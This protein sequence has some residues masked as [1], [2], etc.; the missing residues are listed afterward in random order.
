[1]AHPF[2]DSAKKTSR[3]KFKAISGKSGLSEGDVDGAQL[4]PAPKRLVEAGYAPGDKSKPRPDKRARGGRTPSKININIIS[5]PHAR[6]QA[7][8][9]PLPPAAPL[10]GAPAP[11]TLPF[12][13]GG[14]PL[15]KSGGLVKMTGGAEGG[16]GR[17]QKA[18]NA[19]IRRGA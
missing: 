8:P 14:A 1:M 2:R 10:G 16:L 4:H 19:K 17:L 15:R 5:T 18:R 6:E 12:P 3:G 11:V 13:A 7:G 9:P